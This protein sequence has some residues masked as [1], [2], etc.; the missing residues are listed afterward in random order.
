[1]P[2]SH[3][4]SLSSRHVL[5]MAGGLLFATASAWA[6]LV[7]YPEYPDAIERDWAYEVSV[8]QGSETQGLVVYNHTEKSA[9]T[10]RT[11]GGDVNRRFCEFAFSGEPVRVD[12][13]VCEDVQ[14]YKVFPASLELETSFSNGVISVWLDA[15]HHFGIELH[16]YVKTILSVFVEEPEAPASIPSRN[17]PNVLYIDGWVDAPG[18]GGVYIVS[19]QCSEV[20]IAPGAVLNSRLWIKRPGAHVHGRGMILDPFSDIFRYDQMNNT[21]SGVLKVQAQNVVVED[22]KLIDARTYNYMSF[23]NNA[24]L[25]N[26]KA[27]ASMMCSDGISCGGKNFVVE[28]A[29]LYVGDNGL[30]VSGLSNEGRFSDITIGT[31]C[32]AIFPQGSNTDVYME[33]VNVFR[34]DEGLVW[35]SYNTGTN[36]QKQKFFFK[37]LSAVDSTLFTCFFVG[38]NMGTYVKPFGFENLAI[39]NSTGSANWHAIGRSGGKTI[40]IYDDAGKPW[41]TSNYVVSITN[42]WVNGAQSSGFAESA[43]SWS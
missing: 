14:S 7:I 21:T 40:R 12:I 8:T 24:T 19:N 2:A 20:Y 34:A 37:N 43:T 23:T 4:R 31:S 22:L 1:M 39:P 36:Q 13:R 9:L 35:N 38:A 6:G 10:D 15:P 25:R 41:T 18:P 17:D 42:L 29:W 27:M 30:V 16:D 32:K 3:A 11:R 5:G 28:G 26:V 33:N